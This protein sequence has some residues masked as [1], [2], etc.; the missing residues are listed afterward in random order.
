M[1]Q[2]LI[3]WNI[4]L[5]CQK[6]VKYVN[7]YICNIA[8]NQSPALFMVVDIADIGIGWRSVRTY[9]LTKRTTTVRFFTLKIKIEIL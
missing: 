7:T 3:N 4:I 2:N 5:V 8:I 1:L 9:I 6:G